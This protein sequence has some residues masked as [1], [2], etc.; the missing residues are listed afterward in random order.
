[1]GTDNTEILELRQLVI[2]AALL[3]VDATGCAGDEELDGEVDAWQARAAEALARPE[4][5]ATT[6]DRGAMA[7]TGGPRFGQNGRGFGGE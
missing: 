2:D 1:M 7:P 3:L 6:W 5:L 4:V